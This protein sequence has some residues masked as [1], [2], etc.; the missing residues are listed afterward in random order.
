MSGLTVYGNIH[1]E[2]LR[3][4][5]FAGNLRSFRPAGMGMVIIICCFLFSGLPFSFSGPLPQKKP[6]IRK[7]VI[8]AGHGGHD[9]GTV[10]KRSKEKDIA[11]S[12]SLL[13]GKM[14]REQY[15]EVEVVYTRTTDVFVELYRRAKIANESKA[16]LFIS[17]HCNG[18]RNTTAMGTETWVMGLHKSQENLEVAKKENASI[19][20]EDSYNQYDGFDPNSPEATIVFSLFQNVYL[21]QS[22]DI[23]TRIQHQFGKKLGLVDRGV[24]QAGFWVLYK[25]TMPGILVETGF[26]SNPEDEAYLVSEKGQ[27]EVATAIF[28]AFGEYRQAMDG[29]GPRNGETGRA[30]DLPLAKDEPETEVN[31]SSA[32][33]GGLPA[34]THDRTGGSEADKEGL[35]FK[36]QIVAS[37]KKLS[38]T[39]T[40]FR[41]VKDI[42]SYYHKGVYK[43]TVGNFRRLQE[44][45]ELQAEMQK[46]GF[47]DAFVVAFYKGERISAEEAARI[48]G[49]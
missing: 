4:G 38:S 10:G 9:P 34:V 13:L 36:V 17:I 21:D 44:A 35:A 5:K 37:D 27:K 41:G 26:L 22:L 6:G 32:N 42:S 3:L 18:T 49:K 19:L 2:F 45:V 30:Q 20:M 40:R 28:N 7:I 29:V 25:T 16:D 47:R 8:D 14:I 15:P 39:D 31:R 46:K 24:K 12:V 11:L 43:Y 1:S 48:G 23:A 33:A